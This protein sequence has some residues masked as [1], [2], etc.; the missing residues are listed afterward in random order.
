MSRSDSTR[1]QAII[2][3]TR[4]TRRALLLGT[5]SAAG[6]A[7]VGHNAEADDAPI[8]IT[9]THM[10]HQAPAIPELTLVGTPDGLEFPANVA[11]GLNRVT[12][13]NDTGASFHALTLRVPDHVTDDE[14]EAAMAAEGDPEWF[15]ESYFASNPDQAP[16]G[17]ELSAV[18]T[19]PAGRYAVLNVFT[20]AAARFDAS[21]DSWGRPVPVA[22][23]AI[24][25]VDYGFLALDRAA[26]GRQTWQVTNH[27]TTW[28]DVT[29]F[30]GPDGTTADAFME[31]AMASE[32]FPPAG[33]EHVGGVGGMSPGVSVWVELDLAPGT[34]V[35]A[36]FLPSLDGYQEG[37]PHAMRGM[38][39][40]F[41]VA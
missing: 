35:G 22:D 20:G 29:I 16:P 8:A 9:S 10:D 3:N 40:T 11:A 31:A 27:G 21:G 32:A 41:A 4:I 36:C 7:I 6:L 28:H 2:D 14:L 12:M 25:L 34:Y 18:V 38:S 24:G 17:G 30:R 1:R 15:F 5:A 13:V 26:A 39:T 19:Y 33:Y 37:A 23:R